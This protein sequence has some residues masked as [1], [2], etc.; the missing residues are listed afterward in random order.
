MQVAALLSLL[1]FVT[2]GAG[3]LTIGTMVATNPMQ[4]GPVGVTLWFL[5]LMVSLTGV[6]ALGLYVAKRRVV[7]EQSARARIS[8]CLRQGLLV[9]GGLTVLTALSSLRQLS[10]RDAVLLSILLGLIEFYFR[11]RK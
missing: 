2:V 7:A 10:L 5:V 1:V 6:I 9:G 8:S 3:V 11:S 4:V